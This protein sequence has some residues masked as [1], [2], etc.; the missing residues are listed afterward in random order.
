MMRAVLPRFEPVSVRMHKISGVCHYVIDIN[1]EGDHRSAELGRSALATDRLPPEV[2]TVVQMQA[3]S[4]AHKV[5]AYAGDTP[6][7]AGY[8]ITWDRPITFFTNTPTRIRLLC[9]EG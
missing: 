6:L 8:V 4:D 1:L 7:T 2:L 5:N 9:K 3:D